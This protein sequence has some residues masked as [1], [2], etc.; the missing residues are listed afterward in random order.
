[1]IYNVAVQMHNV[2][3]YMFIYRCAFPV[4]LHI[5]MYMHMH[6]ENGIWQ[7]IRSVCILTPM[8]ALSSLVVTC[9]ALSTAAATC[10]WC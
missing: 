6:N 7:R 3:H 10:C 5:Y 9:L 4:E 8:I 2:M 1:M